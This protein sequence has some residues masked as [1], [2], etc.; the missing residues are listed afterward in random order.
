M[1][2]ALQRRDLKTLSD[3]ELAGICATSYVDYIEAVS[4]TLGYPG[5]VVVLLLVCEQLAFGKTAALPFAGGLAL[6]MAAFLFAH[7]LA[8]RPKRRYREELNYR[9]FSQYV[10]ELEAIRCHKEAD[11]V[12]LFTA[13]GHRHSGFWW[14]RLALK[15][16]PP[17]SA[18]ADLRILPEREPQHWVER[19]VPDDI[20]KDVLCLLNGLDLAALTTP[21]TSWP[22]ASISPASWRRLTVL[23]REPWGVTTVSGDLPDLPAELL[24]HPTANACSKLCDIARCLSPER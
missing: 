10:A 17:P 4:G 22:D 12:L 14:L 11:W 2:S 15:E 6:L 13:S 18:R 20:V 19:E 21:S 8:R 1:R 24:R 3:E 5:S 16:G 7:Q 23:R 9:R